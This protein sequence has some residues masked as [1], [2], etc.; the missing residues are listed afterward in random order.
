MSVIREYLRK[1]IKAYVDTLCMFCYVTL[2]YR[3]L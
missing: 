1:L 3:V 2:G